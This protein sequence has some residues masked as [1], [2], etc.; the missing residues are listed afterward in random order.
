MKKINLK[1][2]Y[3]IQAT[4]TGWNELDIDELKLRMKGVGE[5][6]LLIIEN[7]YNIETK[8]ESIIKFYFFGRLK[9]NED[10]EKSFEEQVL[11]SSWCGFESK[12]KL[13]KHIIEEL[14]VFETKKLQSEYDNKLRKVMSY[15]NAFAH[16][17]LTNIGDEVKLTWFE[18]VTKSETL[19]DSYLEKIESDFLKCI[20]L[21]DQVSLKIGATK[22]ANP[23]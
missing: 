12:R 15:R 16:G 1:N 10:K 17:H 14:L 8:L 6:K 23:N 4:N 21:T 5:N 13:I 2:T 3:T 19:T 7:A 9:I 11:R 18:G 20:E 22:M